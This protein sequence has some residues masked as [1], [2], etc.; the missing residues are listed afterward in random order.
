MFIELVE[1]QELA[2]LGV[3]SHCCVHMR[4][5]FFLISSQDIF[6]GNASMRLLQ[7]KFVADTH[8]H[9]WLNIQAQCC[10]HTHVE[11]TLL[12][13][14]VE[15]KGLM[16]SV[17]VVKCWSPL[18]TLRSVYRQLDFD[19]FLYTCSDHLWDGIFIFGY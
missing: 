4:Y 16:F 9:T 15:H 18:T 17:A 12:S 2:R 7:S 6:C 19:L 11:G 14:M 1:R 13:S 8:S 10:R 3:A 5:I